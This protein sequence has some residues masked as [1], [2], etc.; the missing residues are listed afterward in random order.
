MDLRAGWH[1]RD[2]GEPSTSIYGNWTGAASG[3]LRDRSGRPVD[4]DASGPF[5]TLGLVFATPR[6]R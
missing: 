6:S 3:P 2:L 1:G 5:V 4:F